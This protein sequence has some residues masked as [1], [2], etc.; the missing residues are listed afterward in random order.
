M[1]EKKRSLQTPTI[2]TNPRNILQ[3]SSIAHFVINKDHVIVEWNRAC[4]VLT[5]FSA[6][7]MIGTRNHWMPF[8]SGARPC[9]ADLLIDKAP[10]RTIYKYY[11]DMEIKRWDLVQ[12][13]FDIEGFLAPLGKQGKWLR[14]TAAPL[15]DARGKV[16]AAIETLE[17]ITSRK[18]A[19]KEKEELTRQLLKSNRQLRNLALRD[20]ETGLFNHRYLQEVLEAEFIRAKRYSQ[21]LSLIM[22]DIDY[23]KSINNMYGH[24][25][26]DLVLAQL[27]QLLKKLVRRYDV[28]VRSGGEE[29]TIV[30]PGIDRWQTLVLAQR[31]LDEIN[32]ASFGDKKHMVKLKVSLAVVS[33][34]EDKV[35]KIE[36]LV[37]GA[38]QLLLKA[39]ESGGNRVYTNLEGKKAKKK[40]VRGRKTRTETV[41]SLR[42]RLDQITR[43]ANQN[44]IEAI[45]A[46]A[47]AIELRDHYT[48][49]HVEK[50]VYYALQIG[51][52]LKLSNE[53]IENVRQA[54][55]LHDLGKIGISDKILLKNAKL[56]DEEYQEIKKHPQIAADILRPIHFLRSVIPYILYHHERWDGRGYPSGLKGQIIPVGARIIAIADVFQALT[57][58]RPYRPAFSTEEAVRIIRQGAGT[59]FDPKIVKAFLILIRRKK[60]H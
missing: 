35:I 56:S 49:E 14:F 22:V 20:P 43:R 17:D 59:Q 42:F 55:I 37:S 11:K 32:L 23:F 19:E 36:D 3:G 2:A 39:K 46:F 27:S 52:L 5:G 31:I 24:Q 16:I 54:A 25:F 45:F 34:P 33:Y 12:G 26:G 53:E 18:L 51:R 57:S 58:N 9:L 15:I 41:E 40:S 13:A 30:S 47:K 44:L 10:A 29:F 21:P 8:Y 48:G 60:I 38:E 4:E 1:K 7:R 6:A 50:T 28:V